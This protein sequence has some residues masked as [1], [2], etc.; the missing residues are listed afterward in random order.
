LKPPSLPPTNKNDAVL[1]YDS[2]N[3]VVLA[4]IKQTVGKDQDA[5]HTLS[6]WAYHSTSN[7]WRALKPAREPDSSGN[8]ARQLMFA[9][10]LNA[11]LL[12][13]R[14]EKAAGGPEQQI[15]AYRFAEAK[16]NQAKAGNLK[17]ASADARGRPPLVTDLVV[18]VLSE[19]QVRL[20]WLPPQAGAN[21]AGYQVE[22]AVVDVLSEDQLTR[23]KLRT[24][25]LTTPSAGVVR[26]IGAFEVLTKDPL[27]ASEYLDRVDLAR[28]RTVAK[29]EAIYER[30]LPAEQVDPDGK[31]YRYSVYA[32]RVRSLN[33]LGVAGGPSPAVLTI[34]AA[35]ED[36]F[37]REDGDSC[38]L[39]WRANP[40]EG[41]LGYRVYRLNGRWDKEKV[42]RLTPEHITI[43]SFLDA[44]AGKSTRRYHVIAV[45]ALGQE[46]F[47][48]SPVWFKREWE[49]F[50]RPFLGE[51]HQ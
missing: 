6:T 3:E 20:K 1:A 17:L 5:R 31:P 45:D 7:E 40:E 26:R 46:G 37:A 4:V 18:S 24:E 19:N 30:S 43:L 29:E 22:R 35:V 51:W 32:Y 21:V 11:L 39:K 12:E 25:P 34:P 49:R 16:P 36:L 2:F 48:S 28:V 33:K 13:N 38:R 27:I 15:W 42:P 50:Y 44:T 9:P 8:R 23:L 41:I 47:P 10:E 14:T